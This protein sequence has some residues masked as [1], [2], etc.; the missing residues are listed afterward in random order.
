MN[1]FIIM[2]IFNT[3]NYFSFFLLWSIPCISYHQ[4]N[5]ININL[6]FLNKVKKEKK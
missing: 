1:L 4:V 3:L 5:L 6:M 2:D